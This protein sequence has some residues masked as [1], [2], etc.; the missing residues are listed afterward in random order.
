MHVVA[1]VAEHGGCERIAGGD[2]RLAETQ[3]GNARASRLR[4]VGVDLQRA[5]RAGLHRQARRQEARAG[6]DLERRLVAPDLQRLQDPAGDLRREHLLAVWERNRRVGER[7]LVVCLRN[8]TLARHPSQHLEHALV[9][10]VP[11]AHLL[12]DHL[13]AGGFDQHGRRSWKVG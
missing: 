7:Q 1:A 13:F 12:V 4:E 9:E 3:G 6:A 10:H 8:E 2:L 5:D 11:G